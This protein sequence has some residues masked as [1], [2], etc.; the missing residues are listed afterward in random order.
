M[1]AS[2]A[3]ALNAQTLA[4][5]LYPVAMLTS[6][7]IGEQK[8]KWARCMME[9]MDI[10]QSAAVTYMVCSSVGTSIRCRWKVLAVTHGLQQQQ[11][12]QQV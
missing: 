11:Q 1:V 8:N 2:S 9:V 12:Q 5:A 7:R 6:P 4:L 10:G 3:L